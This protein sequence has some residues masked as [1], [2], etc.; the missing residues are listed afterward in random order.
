MAVE[1]SLENIRNIGIIAHIDAGKTTTTERILFYTG[2]THRLGSV[3]E[4]TT[5]TDWMAQ[6]RERGITITSAAVTCFWKRHQ[7]NIVDTPGHIDFTAEVQRSLRVLDGGIVVFDG[8]SGVEPQSETVWRQAQGFG[9]PLIAFVNKMDKLGADFAHAIDTIH[10]RLKANPVAIQW[11]IGAESDFRGMVDLI[12]WQGIVWSD[13][14]GQ[15]PEYVPVPDEVRGAAE[16]AREFMI[17][18]IVETDDDLM[19]SYLEEE[20]IS[21]DALR[22]ALRDATIAGTIQPVLCGSALRNKGVQPLL[23]AVVQ[24][25]PSPLDIPPVEGE[26]PKKGKVE[27]RPADPSAPLAA[28]IFKIATDPYAGRLAYFRVYSGTVTRGNVY[29]NPGKHTRERVSKLLRMFADR[30]EEVDEIKAGDIGATVGLKA[31]ITGDTLSAMHAPI[32]L[33][34]IRFP[35]PVIQVAVEP[36]TVADQDRLNEALDRLAEEDPTFRVRLDEGTGQTILAGMGELHL[37]VLVDRMLREFNVAA[38]VGKPRVAYRETVTQTG[39]A[40]MTFNR[41]MAGKPQYARVVLEVSP[42]D[43]GEASKFHNLLRPQDLAAEFVEAVRAGALE[44]LD[45]GFL[46]GYPLVGI[47]IRLVDARADESLS[48]EMAFKA[49]AA[50]AFRQAVEAAEPVLLEPMMDVE[51]IMPDGFVGEVL[52]DLNARGAD[53]QLMEPRPGG[54]QAIRAYVPLAKM[55]GY[56]TDLRSVT[57]GRGTFTMEFHHYEPVDSRQMDAIVYGA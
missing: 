33:E 57:Q 56:A 4:G 28:L 7:I 38:N 34:S 32:V 15:K 39:R 26:N 10:E 53:I 9:V 20:E 6:E 21:P 42:A 36:K 31:T 43:T 8:T 52:G 5:I 37:E 41:M 3:D 44:S 25:L 2:R 18:S 45:S 11:P 51:V 48:T 24:Y 46:A 55:F 13:E 14:L 16:E 54:G 23:D 17:E 22:K 12:E 27:T 30:R 49:A 19:V 35:E 29:L 50:Q 40:A 47:E 1:H